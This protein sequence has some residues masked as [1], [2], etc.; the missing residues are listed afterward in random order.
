MRYTKSL[1]F[2][3]SAFLFFVASGQQKNDGIISGI[4]KDSQTK[5]PLNEAVITVSS[6]AFKGQKYALTN[7]KGIFAINNLPPGAYIVSFEMEGYEKY[8]HQIIALKD[9]M[10]AEVSHDMVKE[11]KKS[12]KKRSQVTIKN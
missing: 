12:R 11:R 8:V 4:I 6:N 5:S 9:S 7:S 1:L 2:F 10:T 3:F